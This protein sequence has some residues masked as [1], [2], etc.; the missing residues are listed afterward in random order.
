M[1]GGNEGA[2]LQEFDLASASYEVVAAETP[3][4]EGRRPVRKRPQAVTET[5]KFAVSAYDAAP[6]W[7]AIDEVQEIVASVQARGGTLAY[8]PPNGQRVTFDLN[9]INVDGLPQASP[10]LSKNIVEGCQITYER[11]PFGRLD[12]IMVFTDHVFA[13]PID[14]VELEDVPGHVDALVVFTL[15]DV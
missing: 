11:D 3:D 10:L 12:P 1:Y 5:F 8:I 14:S 6:F 9:L 7:D 13:G 2:F 4:G 15:T